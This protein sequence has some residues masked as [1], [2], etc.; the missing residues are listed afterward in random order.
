[1]N[2]EAFNLE[3]ILEMDPEFLNEGDHQHDSSVGSIGFSFD[4]DLELPKLELMISQVLQEKGTDLFRYKGVIPIK[5][6][7]ER[8]VFQGVHMLFG[9]SFTTPWEKDEPRRGRFIFIG[10]NLDRES[11]TK[12]FEGC[13]ATELRFKVGD[14]VRVNLKRGYTSGVVKKT[15]DDGNA[16]RVYVP[17]MKTEVW[18]PIDSNTYIRPEKKMTTEKPASP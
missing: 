4:Y 2:R 16:Y 10:K 12:A 17:K 5:G 7:K 18:A 13:K 3:K 14:R 8:Y 6:F 9:G 11:V 15:W 1:L